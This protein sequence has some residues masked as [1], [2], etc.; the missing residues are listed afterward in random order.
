MAA[1]ESTIPGTSSR[2]R[3]LK[4]R[5]RG[6]EF[7]GKNQKAIANIVAPMG[8]LREKLATIMCMRPDAIYLSKNTQRQLELEA[9]APPSRGPMALDMAKVDDKMPL[10]GD[11]TGPGTSVAMPMAKLYSPPPPT[12]WKARKTILEK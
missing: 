3:L 10:M 4:V 2:R 1:S 5:L 7:L 12:P 11:R 6:T 9:M 8:T